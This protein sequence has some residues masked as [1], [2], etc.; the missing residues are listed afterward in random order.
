MPS[1]ITPVQLATYAGRQLSAQERG[2]LLVEGTAN[3]GFILGVFGNDRRPPDP[4][5][6]REVELIRQ[7]LTA[8]GARVLGLGL[9][10]DGRSWGMLLQIDNGRYRTPAGRAFYAEMVRIE[11]EEELQR[12]WQAACEA[13]HAP[14]AGQRAG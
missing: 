5:V 10:R 14:V 3:G 13:D 6:N 12:A 8:A 4:R 11:V 7:W 2:V 1:S 9:S